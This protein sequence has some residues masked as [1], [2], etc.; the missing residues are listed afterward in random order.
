MSEMPGPT[1]E[2]KGLSAHQ[3]ILMFLVAVAV[4]AVFFAAGFL[5]GY[6]ERAAKNSPA[7]E[8]VS[9][10]SSA[11]PPV[12]NAPPGPTTGQGR[13][14]T[15]TEGNPVRESAEPLTVPP[16]AS[17]RAAGKPARVAVQ[18]KSPPA[19]PGEGYT[20]QVSASGIEAEA[21]KVIT[22]LKTTGYPAFVVR[23]QAGG[24]GDQ[25]Y[26]VEVGPYPTREL[27]EKARDQLARSG[28]K[29]PFIKH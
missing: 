20:V 23:P 6:N 12:V 2:E 11:I 16:L 4:C 14:A 29:K 10:S 8:N 19:P 25:L 7:T 9:A 13:E 15:A 21:Q 26:R 27:A 1:R 28:F 5:V 22:V 24:K 17:P 18:E 3:L